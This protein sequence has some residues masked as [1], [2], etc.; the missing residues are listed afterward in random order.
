MYGF[1]AASCR[2]NR[3]FRV[4]LGDIPHVPTRSRSWHRVVVPE[5]GSVTCAP[6]DM[7]ERR[8]ARAENRASPGPRRIDDGRP[9]G[10][11][12]R[13]ATTPYTAP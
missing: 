3:L 12:C 11:G 1:S 13:G 10:V 8:A 7:F 9:A 2:S 5:G 6:S 4:S